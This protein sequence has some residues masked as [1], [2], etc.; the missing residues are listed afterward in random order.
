MPEFVSKPA[1]IQAWRFRPVRDQSIKDWEGGVDRTFNELNEITGLNLRYHDESHRCQLWVEKAGQWIDLPP[2]WWVI[3][4][5]DG[6]GFYPCDPDVF[7][8][9]WTAPPVVETPT[10]GEGASGGPLSGEPLMFYGEEDRSF[11]PE[12]GTP[13]RLWWIPNDG[14]PPLDLAGKVRSVDWS[15]QTPT[16]EALR[17]EEPETEMAPEPE[18]RLVQEA[19]WPYE[20]EHLVDRL[21]FHPEWRF[22]LYEDYERDPGCHGTTF[23]VFAVTP[24]AYSTGETRRVWHYFPVPAATFDRQSW[25][26]WLLSRLEDVS[27]HE[28]CEFTRF[29]MEVET[30]EGPAR[31]ERRPFAPNHGPGR[32][33]YVVWSYATDL[34]R[35]TSFRG[36]V[37]PA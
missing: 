22:Y 32:D 24:D 6:S 31:A 20:L 26:R 2:R 12:P 8:Q 13:V 30:E 28:A 18:R 35:K 10:F 9:R 11:A 4:E 21:R 25:E 15:P 37:N 27:R 33:P 19:P 14:S 36:D 29:V 5:P 7:D 3:E 1:T 17:A 34:D 23:A 16:P